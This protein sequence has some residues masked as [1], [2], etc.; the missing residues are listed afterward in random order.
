[1]RARQETEAEREALIDDSNSKIKYIRTTKTRVVESEMSS[2]L[3]L[4][5]LVFYNHYY[6]G[7]MLFLLICTFIY[8]EIM[9]EITYSGIDI[10]FILLWGLA[11]FGRLHY[12]FS[13]NIRE[14]FPELLAFEVITIIFSIPLLIYQFV[15]IQA[16]LP[17][18]KSL[19]IVQWIFVVFEIIFGI[20]AIFR[21]VRN[22]TAIFFLRNSQPDVYYRKSVI[23]SR[24]IE[25]G[26]RG[27]SVG[28][29]RE[30]ENHL[31]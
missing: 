20:L 10:I 29:A 16:H 7:L 19:G 1:M 9:F 13:G 27:R 26:M 4:Q 17:L 24:E 2:N 30:P 3:A 28:I 21:L 12:G 14:N 5:I 8:K 11:E 22:Q 18:E 15:V 31:E 25:V 23:S 6:S